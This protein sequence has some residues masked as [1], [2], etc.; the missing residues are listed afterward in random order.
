MANAND[1][2]LNVDTDFGDVGF[3]WDGNYSSIEEVPSVARRCHT[4]ADIDRPRPPVFACKCCSWCGCQFEAFTL[5]FYQSLV[6]D[7][8]ALALEDA[9]RLR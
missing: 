8:V 3:A 6:E 5:V 7:L 9:R 2:L 4:P 1:E